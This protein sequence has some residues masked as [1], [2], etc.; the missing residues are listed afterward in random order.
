MQPKAIIQRLALIRRELHALAEPPGKEKCTAAYVADLLRSC[1]PTRLLTGLGG[2]GL[3]AEFA[4]P[5]P[6]PRVGLRAELDGLSAN[7]GARHGCG[8]DGHMTLLCGVALG[9]A[10]SPPRSG[11]VVWIFQPAEE[12]GQGAAAML[13]DPCWPDIAPDL[14]YAVHNLPGLPFSQVAIREGVMCL[15]SVGLN[16]SLT[17]AAS[18]AAQPEK[19]RSPAPALA[20]LLAEMPGLAREGELL[21]LTHAR[22]GEEGFGTAPGQALLCATLR[23]SSDQALDSLRVRAERLIDE[24]A[25]VYDLTYNAQWPEP[26]AAAINHPQAAE[27]VRQ[28]VEEWL[29]LDK[30]DQDKEA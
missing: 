18:H 10:Q 24:T 9:L 22:L 4:G 19:G 2:H 8:H 29:A 3:I 20:R 7:Q 12:T 21:T 1:S 11:S 28:A 23:A 15:A 26:F 30:A 14:I 27:I 6:G 17:G 16:A 5:A 25:S 13:A